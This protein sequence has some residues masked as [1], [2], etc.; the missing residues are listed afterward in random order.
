MLPAGVA[1]LV[2]V[3]TI[4][5]V[6]ASSP[7]AAA[8]ATPLSIRVS[9]RPA[10]PE[11]TDDVTVKVRIEHCPAGD[12]EVE[13]YLT[14]D[15]GASQTSALMGRSAAVTSLWFR[16]TALVQ[17]HD[18]AAGWYGVRV[19]CTG[20][21]PP[22]GPLPGTT[23]AVGAGTQRSARLSGTTVAAGGSLQM[24]GDRCV[25]PRVEYE[26]G[27]Q[28]LV[29]HGFRTSGEILTRPDGTWSGDVQFP[30]GSAP[31]PT[32][33]RVRCVVDGI[34]GTSAGVLYDEMP[35][36]TVLPATA[37]AGGAGS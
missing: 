6:P 14:G 15:D 12:V 21:R 3:A 23:F 28:T 5:V 29:Q 37:P 36:V 1:L 19:V 26:V 31:G 33:V 30:A 32:Q 18:A 27:P 7:P 13:V 22:R 11:P 9:T 25:G 24:D 10:S 35:A 8:Q 20:V 16:S 17:L 4:F 2:A 34:D